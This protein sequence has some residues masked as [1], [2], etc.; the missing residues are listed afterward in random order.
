MIFQIPM[1]EGSHMNA[2]DKNGLGISL[3]QSNFYGIGSRIGV[4]SFGFFFITEGVDLTQLKNIQI[5]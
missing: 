5:A 1:E 4:G 3:I 2:V